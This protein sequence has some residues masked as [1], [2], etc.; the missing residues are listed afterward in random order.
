MQIFAPAAAQLVLLHCSSTYPTDPATANLRNILELCDRYDAVVGYSDHT[1]GA[2]APAIAVSLGASVIEKHF[3]MDRSQ[4]GA[5]HLVGVDPPMLKE[6][7]RLIREAELLLG[8]KKRVL[9]EEE[10]NM[11]KAKRRKLV[12]IRDVTRGE[13]L[14]ETNLTCL[15]T[16]STE[17]ID[18]K[19]YDSFITKT[20][21]HSLPRGRILEVGDVN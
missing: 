8:V 9:C 7:M 1:V 5:D 16:K 4:S 6:M 15:Q 12:L 2:T 19:H 18:S 17:G 21:K 11:R 14:D 10:K 20:V 13:A 3:T